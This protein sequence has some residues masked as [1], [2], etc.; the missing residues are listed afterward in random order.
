MKKLITLCLFC[1]I[2]NAFSITAKAEDFNPEVPD[3]IS[4]YCEQA[5]EE[6]DIDANI[7]KALCWQ[8]TRY[9]VYVDNSGTYKGPCQCNPVFYQEE[10]ELLGITD[11]TDPYSNIRLCAYC[12]RNWLDIYGDGT[13]M[14][15]AL[16][17]WNEGYPTALA[18][19]DDKGSYYARNIV[20]NAEVLADLQVE[21]TEKDIFEDKFVDSK[22]SRSA[23]SKTVP[24]S[25]YTPISPRISPVWSGSYY[26]VDTPE[27][28]PYNLDR[29]IYIL[30]GLDGDIRV[31]V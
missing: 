6:F 22:N 5:A 2:F 7:L 24:T 13:D 25:H 3:D 1:F 17:C 31:S 28:A 18:T 23:S 19:H 12:L 9:G 16:E 4:E 8:E 29:Y 11:I 27:I 10:M 21:A 14:Y 20:A 30:K 26:I 15:L